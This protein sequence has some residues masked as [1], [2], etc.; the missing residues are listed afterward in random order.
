MIIDSVIQAY[1]KL[2]DSSSI[3]DYKMPQFTQDEIKEVCQNA[4]D[5]LNTQ[6]TILKINEPVI[7]IGDIHGSFDDLARIIKLFGKPSKTKYLFLGDYVDRG[8]YSVPVILY[9][10]AC[11]CKYPDNVWLIRGNH[12]FSHINKVY[13][14]FDEIINSGFTEIVWEYFQE[15][16]YYLP[17]A[18]IVMNSIFCVHGGLSPSLIKLRTLEELQRPIPN[19]I[20]LPLVSDLVWSDPTEDN[21]EFAAN[22][23]GSGVLF[24]NSSVARFLES[25][26]LQLIVRGHQCNANGVH[27]FSKN[28]GV[29]VF[30]CSDYSGID[31]NKCGAL[32]VKSLNEINIYS[33]TKMTV[34]FSQESVRMMLTPG[35]LGLDQYRVRK[36][37]ATN[38]TREVTNNAPVNNTSVPETQK[39]TPKLSTPKTQKSQPQNTPTQHEPP[40]PVI[41]S[42]A[43][44]KQY[45][46]PTVRSSMICPVSYTPG[47]KKNIRV[48]RALSVATEHG[49]PLQREHTATNIIEEQ[50]KVISPASL[51]KLPKRAFSVED[52]TRRTGPTTPKTLISKDVFD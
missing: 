11:A 40:M 22:Q 43:G 23:R 21:I 12:E 52:F 3:H 28:Q 25:N 46:V 16:F 36:S 42:N 8:E 6:P 31:K 15:V 19:Y 29:T 9:L 1:E 50:T 26:N 44:V 30:S 47:H 51:I 38:S 20:N 45:S 18:A 2:I 5:V 27:S 49:L 24:G 14:F 39:V 10:L 34:G 48:G 4:V 41:N 37:S 13:G 33:L 35:H 32:Q 7:L 17:L